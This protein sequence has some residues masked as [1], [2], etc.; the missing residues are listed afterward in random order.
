MVADSIRARCDRGNQI[1]WTPSGSGLLHHHGWHH[2]QSSR[3]G[4]CCDNP[5]PAYTVGRT[6][7][8]K[9]ASFSHRCCYL[10]LCVFFFLCMLHERLWF[11][12]LYLLDASRLLRQPWGKKDTQ[13]YSISYGTVSHTGYAGSARKKNIMDENV[14]FCPKL[15]SFVTSVTSL[16]AFLFRL[17][18]ACG[19]IVQAECCVD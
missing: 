2:Y 8:I 10:Y 19:S 1:I 14:L 6:N 15:V 11:E 12:I 7:Q 17:H 9:S 3:S 4:G 16:C 18:S 13:G 5:D